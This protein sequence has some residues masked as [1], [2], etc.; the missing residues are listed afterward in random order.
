M[1]NI[2]WCFF[3][4]FLNPADLPSRGCTLSDLV[5]SQWWEGTR[6]FAGV[7]A[8]WLL[9]DVAYSDDEINAERKASRSMIAI[10]GAETHEY[11]TN[12][13]ETSLINEWYVRL[14]NYL[15][16]VRIIA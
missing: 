16:T 10:C 11:M 6:W 7:E 5:Q 8:E 2:S 4:G 15:K 1:R 3:P 12:I 13:A 14:S 9:G